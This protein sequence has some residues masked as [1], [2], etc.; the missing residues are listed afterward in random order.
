[1]RPRPIRQYTPELPTRRRQLR[2][3]IS[4]ACVTRRCFLG[5]PGRS[6]PCGVNSLGR[7]RASGAAWLG[8]LG[9][10]CFA[11]ASLFP[12]LRG[13]RGCKCCSAGAAHAPACGCAGRSPHM[14]GLLRLGFGIQSRA[15]INTACL[16]SSSSVPSA[17][18]DEVQTVGVAQRLGVGTHLGQ[19]CRGAFSSS[20]TGL[21]SPF[22][23]GS[24]PQ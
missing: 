1:M 13:R 2:W 7:L 19:A 21:T 22:R 14:S 11:G 8:W 23:S 24:F 16:F 9:G 18:G 10:K 5:P 6:Q 12:V 17:C 20:S 15:I 3:R 4:S